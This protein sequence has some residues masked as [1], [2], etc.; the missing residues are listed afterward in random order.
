MSAPLDVG[1]VASS[2]SHEQRG[3]LL[4]EMFGSGPFELDCGRQNSSSDR[5]QNVVAEDLAT[6]AKGLVEVRMIVARTAAFTP[7]HQL[8]RLGQGEVAH[9]VAHLD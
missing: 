4:G 9:L 5:G 8:P 3:E 2:T 6:F 1:S 7:Q